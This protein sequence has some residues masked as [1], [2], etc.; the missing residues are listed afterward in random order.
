MAQT[1]TKQEQITTAAKRAAESIASGK[2]ALGGKGGVVVP[3][4][5]EK[6]AL[7]RD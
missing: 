7:K 3:I 5:R 1:Q 4:S 2:A 6:E